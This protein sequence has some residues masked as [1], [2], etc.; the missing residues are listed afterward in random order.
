MKNCK[1]HGLLFSSLHCYLV[2][3][4]GLLVV[5]LLNNMW[6]NLWVVSICT[7]TICTAWSLTPSLCCMLNGLVKNYACVG[8]KACVHVFLFLFVDTECPSCTVLQPKIKNC[9][10]SADVRLQAAWGK[11][12][13]LTNLSFRAS[14]GCYITDTVFGFGGQ[15]KKSCREIL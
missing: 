8:L 15:R 9:S 3:L 12:E 11:Q 5:F 10:G 7:E 4:S 1:T 14:H 13:K 2:L 6:N